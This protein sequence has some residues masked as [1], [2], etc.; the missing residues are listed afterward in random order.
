MSA[1]PVT[2]LLDWLLC[3][4]AIVPFAGAAVAAVWGPTVWRPAAEIALV[5]YATAVLGFIGGHRWGNEVSSRGN[6][7][8][9]GAATLPA[10]AAWAALMLILIRGEGRI[11]L[12][13][14]LAAFAVSWVWDVL[15]P[16]LPGWYKPMR[17]LMTVGAMASVGLVFWATA[18]GG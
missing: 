17:T 3:A 16:Q 8:L 11:G 14:L 2:P 10:L 18:R 1:R 12:G 9:M 5:G 4:A 13:V 6:A 7:F 15:S